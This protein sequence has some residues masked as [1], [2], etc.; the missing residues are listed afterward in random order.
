MDSDLDSVIGFLNAPD[1]KPLIVP[2]APKPEKENL[3]PKP[4]PKSD[5]KPTYYPL[6]ETVPE[7][8]F[9]I[10]TWFLEGAE[11]CE[12]SKN[13]ENTNKQNINDISTNS[14]NH[15]IFKG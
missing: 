8:I 7:G 12:D 2:P 14:K 6:P 15:C 9:L 3:D 1:V 11:E 13:A 10:L 4:I 5:I